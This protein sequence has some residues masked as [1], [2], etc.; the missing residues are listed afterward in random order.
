MNKVISVFG[1]FS[2]N[3]KS[4][5]GQT[6]KT[7]N[8]YN[9]LK[10]HYN[11]IFSIDTSNW[12][13]K[14]FSFL[15]KCIR[16][17]LKTDVC[18]IMPA[19]R[20][21]NVFVPLFSLL[22]RKK[23]KLYYVVIGGW[24]PE[25]LSKHKFLLFCLK[26]FDFIFVETEVMKSKLRNMNLLNVKVL[27]NFK[28][29]NPVSLEEISTLKHTNYYHICTFSRVIKE[30]GI[31]DAIESVCFINNKYKKTIYT[32]DIYGPIG[33]DY[34]KEFDEILKKVPNYIRYCGIKDADE[35]VKV[36]KD[37][38]FLIFPSYYFG[39]GLPGTFI[40]AFCA[41][42]P[43]ISSDW[44]YNSEIIKHEYNGFVFPTRNIDEIVNILEDIY[45]GKYDILSLKRNCLI[46]A[47]KY[48][49]N[50]AIKILLDTI[51][52]DL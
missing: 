38:D 12:R 7:N 34:E 39:E 10:K 49:P 44:K 41:G 8:I 1:H 52:G 33:K 24:L 46:C 37:Y 2:F 5:D 3:R 21:I 50:E 6:V 47:Q 29:I 4:K 28:D 18:I 23:Q 42:V 17:F 13:E 30:K 36:I 51:D 20:G 9:E 43:V 45:L 32:L 15:K 25:Y 22:K 40:D 31:E 19:K 48:N 11:D 27:V 16:R 35:S 14:K 26:K